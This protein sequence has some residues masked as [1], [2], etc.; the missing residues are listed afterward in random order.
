MRSCSHQ[1][2][3]RHS[4]MDLGRVSLVLC[5][6]CHR[7]VCATSHASPPSKKYAHFT[8]EF[9]LLLPSSSLLSPNLY[10]VHLK[11]C[12]PFS[13]SSPLSPSTPH[14]FV[15]PST[16]T[17]QPHCCSANLLAATSPPTHHVLRKSFLHTFTG[18]RNL[19]TQ[20]RNCEELQL[21]SRNAIVQE[22]IE[23]VIRHRK[24]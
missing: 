4:L 7:S 22:E 12:C 9:S 11:N 3:K 6:H 23:E 5:L 14:P 19:K 1:D 17:L 24:K 10:I 8:P 15:I 18:E 2:V 20:G 16:A 21:D 13:L